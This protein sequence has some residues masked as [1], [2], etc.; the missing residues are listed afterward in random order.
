MAASPEIPAGEIVVREGF[1][2][3]PERWREMVR[4]IAGN[5]AR[6]AYDDDPRRLA[7]L[8]LGRC[9]RVLRGKVPAA[10]VALALSEEV[11]AG[12]QHVR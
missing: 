8:A 4:E 5:A 2:I 9:M 10:E 3:A 1:G 12:K 11:E 6:D 7:R